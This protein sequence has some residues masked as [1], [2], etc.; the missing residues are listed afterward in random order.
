MVRVE[1]RLKTPGKLRRVLLKIERLDKAAKHMSKKELQMRLHASLVELKSAMKDLDTEEVKELE[2]ILSSLEG[3]PPI[4]EW[5]HGAAR[6]SSAPYLRMEGQR[7]LPRQHDL[8]VGNEAVPEPASRK[9]LEYRSK[10]RV[11]PT[12][13]LGQE[14]SKKEE[15]VESKGSVKGRPHAGERSD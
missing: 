15:S 13:R 7:A 6:E 14:D 10:F 5:S 8:L 9:K 2:R 11:Q 3:L 4:G 1:H 12:G